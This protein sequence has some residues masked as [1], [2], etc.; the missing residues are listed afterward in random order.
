MTAELRRLAAVHLQW[1]LRQNKILLND[2]NQ[3]NMCLNVRKS[4]CIPVLVHDINLNAVIWS[5]TMVEEYCGW[6]RS[7]L[8]FSLC[9]VVGFAAHLIAQMNHFIESLT[10]RLA[11]YRYSYV[12]KCCHRIAYVQMRLSMFPS[13]SSQ[14]NLLEFALSGSFMKIFNT[15]SKETANY[16]IVVFN[17]HTPHY[18]ITKRKCKFLSNMLSKNVLC[19]ICR[20]F[21]EKQ[22]E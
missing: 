13:Q 14:F 12:I 4:M 18:A 11:K 1:P 22:L 5:L 9:R 8:D 6:H 17:V 16:C 10:L 19:E 7:L 15:R 20:K 2:S 3:L 21:A